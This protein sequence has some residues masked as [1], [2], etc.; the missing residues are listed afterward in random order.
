M[1]VKLNRD[2]QVCNDSTPAAWDAKTIQGPWAYLCD[3]HF[4]T[5]AHPGYAAAA[6]RIEREDDPVPDPT[7]DPTIE[8]FP[9]REGATYGSQKYFELAIAAGYFGCDDDQLYAFK[10]RAMA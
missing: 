3:N 7:I 10:K 9:P 2:C 1:T 4:K 8:V 6:T 5:I